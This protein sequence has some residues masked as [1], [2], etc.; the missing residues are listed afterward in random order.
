MTAPLRSR[1]GNGRA[2]GGTLEWR[3]WAVK[4]KDSDSYL[5]EL[6]FVQMPNG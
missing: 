4:S 3:P 2:C 6:C 5:Q 1:L